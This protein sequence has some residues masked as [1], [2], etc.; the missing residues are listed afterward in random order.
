VCPLICIS[1]T[2]QRYRERDILSST[3]NSKKLI[4]RINANPAVMILS[5]LIGVSGLRAF[6]SS[7]VKAV[8]MPNPYVFV[9]H[10]TKFP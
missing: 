7:T 6:I 8:A 1:Y 5:P 4:I 2:V 10:T 3:Q 9:E